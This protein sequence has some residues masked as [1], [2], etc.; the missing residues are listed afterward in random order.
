LLEGYGENIH[1]SVSLREL[2]YMLVR[3]EIKI[4]KMKTTF[5]F[6]KPNTRARSF[7]DFYN[8]STNQEPPI[9]GTQ[10][11]RPIGIEDFKNIKYY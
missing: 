4:L 6:S 10:S 5:G 2:K 1:Q 3:R 11:C 7:G 9:S 8:L